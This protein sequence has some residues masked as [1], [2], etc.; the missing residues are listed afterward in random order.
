MEKKKLTLSISSSKKT[1]KSIEEAK[2]QSKNSVIIERK[3]G[4]FSGKQ[5]FSRPS[6]TKREEI[7]KQAGAKMEEAGELGQ[8]ARAMAKRKRTEEDSNTSEVS[9][10]K[11]KRSLRPMR[12]S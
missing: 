2:Y 7:R 8:V 6:S 10:K 1:I 12:R 3:S 5:R 4:K 11:L 9:S